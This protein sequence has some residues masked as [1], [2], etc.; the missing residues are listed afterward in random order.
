MM[1]WFHFFRDA[2][3]ISGQRKIGFSTSFPLRV[4]SCQFM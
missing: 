4:C 2:F 1:S 3:S